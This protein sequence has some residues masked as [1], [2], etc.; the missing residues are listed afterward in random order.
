MS[1]PTV[2]ASIAAGSLL[3]LGLPGCGDPNEAERGAAEAVSGMLARGE[4]AI[5]RGNCLDCHAAGEAIASRIAP[6]AAPNIT[7]KGSVALRLTPEHLERYLLDPHAV[8]PDS[9]MPNVLHGLPES[10]RAQAARDLVHFLMTAP[11][12]PKDPALL[13]AFEAPTPILPGVPE[14]GAR[15][16]RTI[17]CAACHGESPDFDRYASSTTVPAFARMLLDPTAI[18]TSGHMPSM[19]LSEDEAIAIAA[20]CLHPQALDGDTRSTSHEEGLAAIGA[21]PI[22]RM[23]GLLAE[24][25]E[26]AFPASG[27]GLEGDFDRRYVAPRP[28]LPA[29][30]PP[31]M[32]ALR[33]KGAIEIPTAGEWTFFLTSDDGSRLYL[34][35]A[36]AIANDGEHGMDTEKTSRE[37]PAGPLPMVLTFYQA[38]GEIGLRF[39]WEG[40]GLPREV[41]PASAFTHETLLYAPPR[42]GNSSFAAE[43]ERI[44]RGG[45]LFLEL[46]C[47]NCHVP[48]MAKMFAERGGP[49][50]KGFDELDPS[51]GCLAESVPEASPLYA[52]AQGERD[53]IREVVASRELLLEP[54]APAEE[55]DRTLAML[56]CVVCH[57]RDGAGGP[58]EATRELFVSAEEADMGDQGRY[59]PTLTGVGDKL[60]TEAIRATLDGDARVRPYLATRMPVYGAGTTARL[61]VL[62][63]VADAI[64]AHGVEPAFSEESVED[65]RLIA[66][67]EGL[68]CITCHTLAGHKSLGIPAVDLAAMHKRLRPGWFRELLLQPARYQPGTRMPQF[69]L[70]N[71]R[72]MP[73]IEGGDPRRQI[74]AVWN[75]LSLGASMPL[76]EGLVVEAGAYHLDPSERPILFGTFMKGVSPRTICVGFP[77]RLHVAYDAQANRLAKAWRGEFMDAEGTWHARAGMLEE[78]LGEDVVEFAPADAI[79]VVASAESPWPA[80][81]EWRGAGIVRDA[82]GVPSFVSERVGDS[83]MIELRLREQAVPR[84]RPG[85]AKLLRT[86]V[87]ESPE[88]RRDLFHRAAVGRRIEPASTP[89]GEM[90]LVDGVATVSFAGGGTPVLR[91]VDGGFEL[92]VPLRFGYAEGEAMPYRA[93]LAA[94]WSW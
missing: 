24:L 61:P 1:R 63:E 17:G 39:E 36:V 20:W 60:R 68:G 54:L 74:D 76:P 6:I 58:T 94:E 32:F 25:V 72:I 70:P 89:A 19:Q 7:G 87:V 14:D 51:K 64:P 33:F 27:P 22:H 43:P 4:L 77:Q 21:A 50:A 40:P 41:V 88:S 73:Q 90:F 10:E 31:E 52:F 42:G 56:Q 44:D 78:P 12:T 34:D 28:E 13:A 59:P 11:N 71:E 91:E 86:F 84:P 2:A 66:G 65:G 18:W 29:E 3:A 48:R 5:S 15:L 69:W 57:V 16:Y 35:G 92:L 79:A 8:K 46:G 26:G 30:H 62:F 83:G 49:R 75:Y 38:H 9:R 55:L 53:A 45:T 47:M 80:E 82:E 67:T 85:G 23:P 37:L 81:P 93:E